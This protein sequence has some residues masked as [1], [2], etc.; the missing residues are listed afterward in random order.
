M[1]IPLNVQGVTPS[2]PLARR[3]KLINE[4]L[5]ASKPSSSTVPK[6]DF[7]VDALKKVADS[8]RDG[9]HHLASISV[10][11]LIGSCSL[12]P[13]GNEEDTEG[14][15]VRRLSAYLG[16]C[17]Y[18]APLDDPMEDVIPWL[19][20]TSPDMYPDGE[21]PKRVF[22]PASECAI[23]LN[24][25]YHSYIRGGT[26]SSKT[27]LAHADC[28][29]M[30]DTEIHGTEMQSV[31][32]KMAMECLQANEMVLAEVLFVMHMLLENPDLYFLFFHV[33]PPSS[34]EEVIATVI[35]GALCPFSSSCG[36]ARH[37]D[38]F[39]VGRM[40][41]MFLLCCQIQQKER[42]VPTEA[43]RFKRAVRG[44]RHRTVGDKS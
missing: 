2:D 14:E 8:L 33:C 1:P 19:A 11:A 13:A 6:F 42:G 34:L 3:Q 23:L 30:M 31:V 40:W 20:G 16:D 12:F 32:W 43:C 24:G 15:F 9:K 39:N 7:P 35:C 5:D 22:V 28:D 10:S 44:D 25:V 37:M 18:N 4:L 27:Y 21:L 38:C 29:P 41:A 36:E 17:G 26:C